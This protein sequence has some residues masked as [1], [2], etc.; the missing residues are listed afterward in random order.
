[1]RLLSITV[2][3]VA[4][5]VVMRG[6]TPVTSAVSDNVPMTIVKSTRSVA[7]T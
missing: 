5:S 4:F 1:M 6:E 2:P 7:S 3:I